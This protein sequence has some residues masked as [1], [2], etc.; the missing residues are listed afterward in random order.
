MFIGV[1]YYENPQ[2]FFKIVVESINKQESF[3]NMS[4]YT[5]YDYL[6]KILLIGDS[7]VGKSCLLM[8]FMDEKYSDTYISTIGVDFKIR[9]LSLDNKVIKMQ[10]WDTAG[11]E[12]FRTITSSY[13][14]GAHGI[15][16]VYDITDADSFD[17]VR[18]W[19]KEIGRYANKNV[20]ILVVGNKLDLETNRKVPCGIVEEY[21]YQENIDCFE[22]SAKENTNVTIFFEK[23]AKKIMRRMASE[24]LKPR[25]TEK[26]KTKKI[27]PPRNSCC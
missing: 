22:T 26:W 20:D 1:Y 15:I 14:R 25:P 9:T 16:V 4:N 3:Y 27:E 23:M 5:D 24:E 19:L 17:N 2:T 6:F 11:Q 18:H 7:G 21:T 8:R 10:I 12:R 13:Y